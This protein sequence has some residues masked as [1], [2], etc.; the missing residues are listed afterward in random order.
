ML[1]DTHELTMHWSPDVEK[2]KE[3][4]TLCR[5]TRCE[6]SVGLDK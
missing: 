2:Q 3:A 4:S 1:I 5:F 6:K